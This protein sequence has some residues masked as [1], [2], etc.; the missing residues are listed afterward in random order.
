[1]GI[2]GSILSFFSCE[3]TLSSLTTFRQ[4]WISEKKYD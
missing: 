1:M 3:S 4:L 2:E